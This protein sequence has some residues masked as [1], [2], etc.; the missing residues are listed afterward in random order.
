MLIM[1]FNQINYF[2]AVA[3]HL[4]FTRAAAALFV[5][6][7]TLSRSI[8]ALETELG[9][10][11]LERDFHNVGLTPAGELM[12]REMQGIMGAINGLIR[13]VQQV[14]G[15]ENDRLVIGILEGQAVATSMLF[16]IRILS[17]NFPQFSVDIRKMSHQELIEAIKSRDIDIAE[18]ILAPDTVLDEELLHIRLE[19]VKNYLVAWTEDPIWQRKPSLDSLRDQTLIIPERIHPGVD[20]V[21]RVLAEAGIEPAVRKASDMETHSLWLDAGVGVSIC[22]EG[23][24]ICASPSVRPLMAVPLEELPKV[25]IALMWNKEHDTPML[26][27]FLNYVKSSLESGNAAE[28]PVEKKSPIVLKEWK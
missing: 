23:H 8:A 6:Q 7:S 28:R 10:T 17:D 20:C 1:T 24:V 4:N 9:V 11:L 19:D 15:R 25:S 22:N 5:T 12:N 18:T 13:R 16:A 2:L 26:S 3:Q 14:D 27:R 21:N